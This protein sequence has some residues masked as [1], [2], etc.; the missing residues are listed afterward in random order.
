MGL[1]G[2][3]WI[4]QKPSHVQNMS[5][6]VILSLC[7]GVHSHW[8]EGPVS[9]SYQP[10]FRLQSQCVLPNYPTP[11]PLL[12]TVIEDVPSRGTTSWISP[13]N[14]H[15]SL[16]VPGWHPRLLV[17]SLNKVCL[18]PVCAKSFPTLWGY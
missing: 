15:V 2:E 14:Q 3:G 9:T 18:E 5:P 6:R 13:C 16:C 17:H 11:I 10:A 7:G 1:N 8:V 12:L 4:R